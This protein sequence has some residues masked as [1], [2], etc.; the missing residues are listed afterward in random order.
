MK[1][2]II[3][4]GD[5]IL[6]G[7]VVDTNS[8]WIA[9]QLSSLQIHVKQITSIT[10]TH[11]HI[12][13]SLKEASERADLIIC[14]G[15]LGPTKDDVTKNV[16][17]VYFNTALVQNDSV[18]LHVENIFQ[19]IN[20]NKSMPV[21]NISQAA[22]LACCEVLFNDW[23][24]A[25]GMWIE[26]DGKIYVFLP[27]VP[28]EMKKLI[29][30]RVLPRLS[31][32]VMTEKFVYRHLLVIGIGESHLA[33][34][35]EKIENAFSD[36]VKL[37][38][39]PKI[40]QVRLRLSLTGDNLSLLNQEADLLQNE[41]IN[42]I[43][44]AVIATRD[45]SFEEV[46]IN[47]FK[48]NQCTLAT[49][50]SCT[51]G[52]IAKQI[53]EISGA[54]Q[55]FIGSIVAYANKVKEQLLNVDKS[56]LERYGAVSE[57]TVIEMAKGV[58]ASL[59]TTY[60]IATSGIAGPTGGSIDKPVGS[61]WIAVIGKKQVITKHFQF[62]DDRLLNIERATISALLLL[63]NLFLQEKGD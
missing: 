11:N 26:K 36:H 16:A 53:T 46:I 3:T 34:K 38:F 41:L 63:W 47:E 61:V 55:V 35:I 27:G 21:S 60:A 56:T 22:V 19:K 58:K 43:G 14:T 13:S 4:I 42:C 20:K 32:Y 8:T 49:A 25:P 5:E 57:E 6:L 39:L 54:S 2:E 50:E 29:T 37:A 45:V 15:G 9:Q 52:N 28:F 17:A 23:G 44:P 31:Q 24:T 59:G 18:L 40:G 48:L 12:L 10:D 1:A 30:H 51:G 62:T 33:E 7:Q